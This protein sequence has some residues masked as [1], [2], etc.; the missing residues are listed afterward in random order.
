[1]FNSYFMVLLS[2]IV[3]LQSLY[4]NFLFTIFVCHMLGSMLENYSV[5]W[6]GDNSISSHVAKHYII[7]IIY[8]NSTFNSQR[9]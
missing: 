3:I 8:T 9:I 4:F 7:R 6:E 2:F 5:N 1:M